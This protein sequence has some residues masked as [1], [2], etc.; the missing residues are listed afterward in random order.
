[1]RMGVHRDNLAAALQGA[2]RVW[3][4]QPPGLDW[5]LDLVTGA[6]DVPVRVMD[7]VAALVQSLQQN[8]VPGDHVLIMSNGGFGGLHDRLLKALAQAGAGP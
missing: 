7:S 3:L 5:S 2:D 8:A 4:Y 6:L 1:M